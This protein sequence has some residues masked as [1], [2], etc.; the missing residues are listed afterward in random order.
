MTDHCYHLSMATPISVLFPVRNAQDTVDRALDSLWRQTFA[1]FQ[2]IAVDDGSTDATHDRLAAHARRESRLT[3]VPTKPCGI[4][5]ALETARALAVSPFLARMDA[6]DI[7]HPGR[8]AAQQAYLESRPRV[9]AVGSRITLVPRHA[10]GAGWRRY[11]RWINRL[12]TPE[13]HARELFIESPLAHPSVL[14]RSDAV[15]TVGGYRDVAWAEDYDLW[16]RLAAAGRELGKVDRRLLAWRQTDHRLSLTDPRY[17]LPAFLAARAHYLAKH[18]ITGGETLAMWGAGKTGR[19]LARRLAREG[20]RVDR[21][22]DVDPRR[23][24]TSFLDA[25]IHSWTDLEPA[26]KAPLLVA[27]GAA[28]ARDLI[29]PET[30]RKGYREGVDCLFAA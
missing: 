22:Y 15:A 4:V 17:A 19:R 20:V 24:G 1:D 7:S 12:I 8:F 29:R 23:I 6:D 27:V 2:V 10:L 9:A 18:P 13:D 11:E 26:G 14:M 16:L 5:A 21:F 28:G 25:P 3:V 30:R